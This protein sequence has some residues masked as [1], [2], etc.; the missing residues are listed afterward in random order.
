[1]RGERRDQV[2][3]SLHFEGLRDEPANPAS[4]QRF[5]SRAS[6]KPV[7]ATPKSWL[8]TDEREEL[9]AVHVGHRDVQ[10]Q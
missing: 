6:S 5:V 10:Q 1:V 9:A 8:A 7:T 4:R 3:Q 2:E